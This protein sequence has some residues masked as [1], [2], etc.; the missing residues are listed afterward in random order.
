MA[1]L[2]KDSI[3]EQHFKL[4]A[5]KFPDHEILKM[6]LGQKI[7]FQAAYDTTGTGA[8]I[9][10]SINVMPCTVCRKLFIGG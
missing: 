8:P 4:L 2:F 1:N 9:W 3:S 6:Y 10:L 7:P 5:V